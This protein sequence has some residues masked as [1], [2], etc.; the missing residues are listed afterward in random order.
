MVLKYN[1]KMKCVDMTGKKI[2]NYLIDYNF[3][4]GKN[5]DQPKKIRIEIAGSNYTV[6]TTEQ[7]GY[8]RDLAAEI[9]GDIAALNE[10][11]PSLSMNDALVLCAIAY[12]DEYKKESS[13]SDHI[14]SQLKE[15]IGDTA[16]ARMEVDEANRRADKLQKELDEMRRKHGN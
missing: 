5:M 12:L 8:V 16:K 3:A 10:K 7:E 6:M 9:S 15:Y 4:G 11:N 14:R 1:F 2:Y 13:N